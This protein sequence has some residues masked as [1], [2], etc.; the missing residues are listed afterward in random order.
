MRPS[1]EENILKILLT[2]MVIASAVMVIAA[3]YVTDGY[4]PH[5]NSC[6]CVAAADQDSKPE[7]GRCD[8]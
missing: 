4:I 8:D 6:C 3:C 2:V 5:K 1:T 7:S